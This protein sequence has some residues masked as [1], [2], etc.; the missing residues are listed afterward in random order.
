MAKNVNFDLFNTFL[1]LLYDQLSK[2]STFWLRPH[3][4]SCCPVQECSKVTKIHKGI[5]LCMLDHHKQRACGYDQGDRN[6][7][8]LKKILKTHFKMH[9]GTN[10]LTIL[11]WS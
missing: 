9:V 5:A 1:W 6:S 10:G 8:H 4:N 3:F 11:N 2:S 7:G